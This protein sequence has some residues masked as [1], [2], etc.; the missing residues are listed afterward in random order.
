MIIIKNTILNKLNSIKNTIIYDF[1]EFPKRSCVKTTRYNIE[2]T[3]N[4]TESTIFEKDYL[5]GEPNYLRPDEISMKEYEI[6]KR[7]TNDEGICPSCGCISK[8]LFL[9][10]KCDQKQDVCAPCAIG[11]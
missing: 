11:F 8:T 5:Y 9:S 2:Y 1:L 6:I 4:S 3:S 7:F 10:T